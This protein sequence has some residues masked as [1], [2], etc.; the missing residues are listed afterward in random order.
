MKFG[1]IFEL[2]DV[3]VNGKR[4][5]STSVGG[6]KSSCVTTLLLN[7]ILVYFR[8]NGFTSSP[9]NSKQVLAIHNS[10]LLNLLQYTL[11]RLLNQL[12]VEQQEVFN[13]TH[14]Y[15]VPETCTGSC[16]SIC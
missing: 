8:D 4:F 2:T 3:K 1:H 16:A 12:K 15:H 9:T 7:V 13:L 11:L 14:N 5:V 6:S 10:Q